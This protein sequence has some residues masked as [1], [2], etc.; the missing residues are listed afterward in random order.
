M[1]LVPPMSTAA[2]AR[3]AAGMGR[4]QF[5]LLTVY[6]SA[7]TCGE[8]SAP[9]ALTVMLQVKEPTFV[10]ASTVTVGVTLPPFAARLPD[11]WLRWHQPSSVAA[12]QLMGA[13]PVSVILS[14]WP[15]GVG[16]PEYPVKLE[17]TGESE[18][19]ETS[20]GFTVRVALDDALPP[21]PVQV[22]V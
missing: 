7:S 2:G 22:K 11:T 18:I 20:G 12:V 8:L 17:L 16:P 6:V 4:G 1:A 3:F 19:W 21:G 15:A 10:G 9:E 5:P 14:G 13:L